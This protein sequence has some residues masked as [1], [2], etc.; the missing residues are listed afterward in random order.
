MQTSKSTA[1]MG[2]VRVQIQLGEGDAAQRQAWAKLWELLLDDD[3]TPRE[4]PGACSADASMRPRGADR[5]H[6]GADGARGNH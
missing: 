3:S 4:T 1:L 2:E 5:A 6:E